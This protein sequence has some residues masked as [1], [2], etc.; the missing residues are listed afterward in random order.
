MFQIYLLELIDQLDDLIIFT[1]STPLS[2]F[3]LFVNSQNLGNKNSIYS[4]SYKN[5]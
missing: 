2:L 1:F 4:L 3:C 5:I